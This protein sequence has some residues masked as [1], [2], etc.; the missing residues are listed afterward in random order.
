MIWSFATTVSV[1]GVI[2]ALIKFL[3]SSTCLPFLSSPITVSFW[4]RL[5][6]KT[7]RTKMPNDAARSLRAFMSSSTELDCSI[8]KTRLSWYPQWQ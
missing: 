7:N 2:V 6:I 5:I 4:A 8:S 1:G 3:W